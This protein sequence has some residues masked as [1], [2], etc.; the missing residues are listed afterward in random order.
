MSL[1]GLSGLSGASGVAGPPWFSPLMWLDASALALNN[2]DPIS[3]FTDRS[4]NGN[5]PTAASTARPTYLTNQQNGLP[6]ASFDGSNDAM[7]LA[8][9][10]MSGAQTIVWVGK[11]GAAAVGGKIAYEHGANANSNPGSYLVIQST[12]TGG[13][14]VNRGGGSSR[15]VAT[16]ASPAASTAHI[17]TQLIDGN[18]GNHR[19]YVDGAITALTPSSVSNPGTGNTAAAFYLGARTAASLFYGGLVFECIIV[20]RMLTDAERR[21]LESYL[22]AKWAISY[23]T[24]TTYLNSDLTDNVYSTAIAGALT[25]SPLAR[26]QFVTTATGV[27]VEAYTDYYGSFPTLSSIGVR[28]DGADNS[29]Q[30]FSA[31]NQLSYFTP[32]IGAGTKT[33]E[34]ISGAQSIP[35]STKI[36]NWLRAVH[37]VG[38]AALAA[39]ATPRLVIYGD[40]I[41][42]GANA[43]SP[44]LD[45]WTEKV[46]QSW[47]GGV[48][49]EAWGSRT[50]Y[51]DANTSG[52]RAALVTQLAQQ[53]PT[54][55][56][57]AIGTNDYALNKWTAASFGTAYAALLDDL[58]T[59]LPSAT[60]YCQTPITRV[61]PAVETANGGGSTL[62]NYRTQ[63]A[64]AQSTRSAYAV[65]VDGTAIT[66]TGKYDTDGIH[67]TTTGHATYAAAVKTVLGI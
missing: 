40:S 24:T 56:W 58:H 19:C 10:T 11:P 16:I 53:S 48:T 14:S 36:G 35:A 32:T 18:A 39:N 62:G 1:A 20:N 26:W 3:T 34:V 15:S 6:A 33:I 59:A 46:R 8:S 7:T 37:I 4:G 64:T 17:I 22:A 50:L 57:L 44:A 27:T 52:L 54:A 66:L 13:V 28:V 29:T 43:T 12:T 31:N 60:I 9:L 2:N 51:D 65:L 38:A 30:S 47:P 25:S 45:A 63:I 67:P 55:I 49:L 5:S 21:A 23:T 42:V 61:S 41:T